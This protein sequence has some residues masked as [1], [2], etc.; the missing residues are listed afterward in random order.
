MSLIE[1]VVFFVVVSL[2]YGG[3]VAGIGLFVWKM[4]DRQA[5]SEAATRDMLL[6]QANKPF[7]AFNFG[8]PDEADGESTMVE[9]APA[10]LDPDLAV[11]AH[12][13]LER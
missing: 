2:F 11:L 6:K 5:T 1:L 10:P 4:M 8:T 13:D 9:S 3:L 12:L 7:E